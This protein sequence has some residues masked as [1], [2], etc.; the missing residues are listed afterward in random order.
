MG[1][2]QPTGHAGACPPD[3]RKERAVTALGPNDSRDDAT[4]ERN[5]APLP[6][7]TVLWMLAALTVVV[8][9]TLL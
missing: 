7:S 1:S 3:P 5:A 6:A 4:R 2:R 8:L 9:I